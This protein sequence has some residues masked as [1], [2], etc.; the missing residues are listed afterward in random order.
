MIQFSINHKLKMAAANVVAILFVSTLAAQTDSSEGPSLLDPEPD[1]VYKVEN[2]FKTTKVINLQSVEMLGAGVLDVKINHRFG[3]INSGQYN[4]YGLDNS[5]VRLGGEYGINS[6]L[7]IGLGRQGYDK[8]YDA[9]LKYRIMS[10]TSDNKKPFSVILLGSA[11]YRNTRFT[12]EASTLQRMAYVSQVT[13]GR[14]FSEIFSA[15]IT[16]N[17]IHFNM[18]GQG[19]DN[20]LIAGGIGMRA[21]LTPRTT[22]NVEYIPVFGNNGIYK[23]SFSVG[24]DVETGGHVFQLHFTNST[25]MNESGFIARTDGDWMKGGVR[26]GFNIARVFTL[27]D[28][29]RFEKH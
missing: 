16:G 19:M 10:Q 8:T 21:K 7:T 26:F 15:Q 13:I 11:T 1:P 14:K 4:F 20:S 17:Y 28:P 6:N 12:Y 23:N 5:S 25:A 3:A 2:I 9:F 24:F 27:V 29:T 22:F 18:V